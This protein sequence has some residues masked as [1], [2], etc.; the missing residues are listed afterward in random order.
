MQNESGP[1][2]E[3]ATVQGIVI[4]CIQVFLL[5]RTYESGTFAD[6]KGDYVLAESIRGEIGAL[7][8]ALEPIRPTSIK[9]ILNRIYF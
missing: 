2:L 6:C 3:L 5:H 7:N 4:V 9:R 1:A 8:L